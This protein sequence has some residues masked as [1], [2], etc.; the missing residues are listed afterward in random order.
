M[1]K[2]GVAALLF[3]VFSCTSALHVLLVPAPTQPSLASFFGVAT[4]IHGRGHCVT[5]ASPACIQPAAA[6]LTSASL[7]IYPAS[8]LISIQRQSPAAIRSQLRPIG[9]TISD[10]LNRS[11]STSA[12]ACSSRP[13]VA[14]VDFDLFPYKMLDDSVFTLC[15]FLIYSFDSEPWSMF[16]MRMASPLQ[17]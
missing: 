10:A 15:I 16:L 13:N 7:L 8:E 14:L 17:R 9:L 6:A 4:D 11:L 1:S 12:L 2:I 5:L 3:A